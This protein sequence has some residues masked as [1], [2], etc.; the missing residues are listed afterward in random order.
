ML[1]KTYKIVAVLVSSC[2]G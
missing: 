1:L 2:M